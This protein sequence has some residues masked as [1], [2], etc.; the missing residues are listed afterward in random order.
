MGIPYSKQINAAFNQVT[1]L[2]ASGYELLETVKNIALFITALQIGLTFITLLNFFAI[3]GVIISVNPDLDKERKNL[4][5]PAVKW[6]ASWGLVWTERKWSLLGIV[7]GLF[8]VMAFAYSIYLY[9]ARQEAEQMAEDF[10]RGDEG[11]AEK[12]GTGGSEDKDNEKNDKKSDEK[13]SS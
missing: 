2:V 7:G 8:A 12:D 9:H 10:L 3:L 6:I 13:S 1:P 4:V 5:T 11:L